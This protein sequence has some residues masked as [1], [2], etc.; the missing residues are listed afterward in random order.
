MTLDIYKSEKAISIPIKEV[1]TEKSGYPNEKAFYHFMR[2][3]KDMLKEKP[4]SVVCINIDLRKA[5]AQSYAYGD[6][7]L[8][9]F[10]TELSDYYIFRIQGEKFNILV[11]NDRLEELKKKLDEPNDNYEIYYGISK[12]PLVVDSEAEVKAYIRECISLMFESKNN[13]RNPDKGIIGDKGN[14]PKELQETTTKKF[15]STMWYSEIKVQITEPTFDEFTV[16]VFP[17]ELK[18]P[19]QSIP[20]IVVIYDNL[21]YR[22]LFSNNVQFGKS[23]HIFTVTA[24]FDREG[25]L[26]TAIYDN[27]KGKCQFKIDTHEGVCVPVNFGKRITPTREIYPIRKNLQG[28]CDYV[29]LENGEVTLNTEGIVTSTSGTQYGVYMDSKAIDLIK[30][31]TTKEVRSYENT[32]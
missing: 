18:Q 26:N 6:Y 16:Y 28:Y 20:S 5:N 1:Y 4:Y 3:K 14:T 13:K 29:S 2:K 22:V 15:R 12:K 17:T 8:R 23:N 27:G 31:E 30:L 11:E 9:K 7:V 24:R 21:E 32:R 10:V 19:L 25:H